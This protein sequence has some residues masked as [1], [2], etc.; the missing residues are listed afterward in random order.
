[1]KEYL[2]R[3]LAD[4]GGILNA[5][6]CLVHCAAGPVLWAWW[7]GSRGAEPAAYWDTV[8]LL[9]SGVLVAAAT[10]RLVSWRL[11][12]AFW[13][14]LGLFAIT[15]LLAGRW[16]ELEMVQY[17]ASFGLLGTHLLNLRHCRRCA[18]NSPGLV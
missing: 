1:M 12:V 18:G 16:P 10:R 5:G 9:V 13:A 2:P 15:V 11:R 4:Y 8:F 14:F 7:S 6:L 17:A 3:A